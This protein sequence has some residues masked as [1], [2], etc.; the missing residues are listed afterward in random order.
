LEASPKPEKGGV[1]V[2]LGIVSDIHCNADGLMLALQRMGDV[3]ELLCAGDAFYEYRFS[4]EVIELLRQREARYV[5]GNH[6]SVLLHP[7][8]VRAREA[9][10]VRRENLEYVA[11]RPVGINF[12]VDGM[13]L[14]MTHASPLAPNT[15]YVYPNSREL[16]RLADVE[17]D[18]IILGH[19]HVQMATRVGRALVINPGS[20]GEARDTK[21]GRRLSYA[22]L[23]T[24]S[25]QVS[26]DNFLVG[27]SST[28]EFVPANA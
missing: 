8:G 19:T 11:S 22:V 25:G 2:R 21:N 9:P 3:D 10:H 13:K 16:E 24:A 5:L 4:N 14:L 6:E 7:G 23:D 18:Y 17:A 1:G 27:D 28:P 26:I 12:V 20:V 15:Q